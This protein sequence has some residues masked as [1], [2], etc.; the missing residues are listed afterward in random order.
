MNKILFAL[1]RGK[2]ALLESPTG[3]GKTLALLC[4]TLSWQRDEF[5]LSKEAASLA[6]S[7]AFEAAVEKQRKQAELAASKGE[8]PSEQKSEG[9][10]RG[11][12]GGGDGDDGDDGE[13]IDAE[14]DTPKGKSAFITAAK[15]MRMERRRSVLSSKRNDLSG[16]CKTPPGTS[17]SETG[18]TS[19]IKEKDPPSGGGGSGRGSGG[20]ASIASGGDS[21][22]GRLAK[23]RARKEKRAKVVVKG[24]GGGLEAFGFR[25]K[26]VDNRTDGGGSYSGSSDVTV[27][28]RGRV[29][30]TSGKN[31]GKGKGKGNWKSEFEEMVDEESS[32]S[33]STFH[34]SSHSSSSSSHKPK[35]VKHRRIFFA[36]RTHSQIEQV[37]AELKACP[38]SYRWGFPMQGENGRVE[39]GHGMGQIV[40]AILG[41]RRHYC[42]HPRVS[43]KDAKDIDEGCQKLMDN[44]GGC[45]YARMAKPLSQALRQDLRTVNEYG[46]YE[47][48]RSR[49]TGRSVPFLHDIEE[50]KLYAR[51]NGACPYFASRD[52]ASSHAHIVFCPY[53]YLISP[54][55]RKAMEINLKDAVVIFDEAH[56]IEDISRDA[57][58][59]DSSVGAIATAGE[60]ARG[61]TG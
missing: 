24:G 7:R 51:N 40:M 15:A 19:A 58:S 49:S 25:K 39:K 33:S 23:V 17:G 50:L 46:E 38:D 20:E 8:T 31:K 36:S 55:I 37:V 61:L 32:S 56:N 28:E 13:V 53:N 21:G 5:E 42:V 10:G 30:H 29:C 57:A 52:L 16:A 59:W 44:K 34:S 41:S 18:G 47:Q 4:S 6:A 43:K 48:R 27:L 3:T 2:H 26:G 54:G 35:R 22:G 9:G 14:A 45:S 1:K 60:E 11:G 12:G